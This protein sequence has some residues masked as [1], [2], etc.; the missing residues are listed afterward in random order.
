M[1]KPTPLEPE[2]ILWLTVSSTDFN[3]TPSAYLDKLKEGYTVEVTRYNEESSILRPPEMTTKKM[4]SFAVSSGIGTVKDDAE[5]LCVITATPY[6]IYIT[7]GTCF[8]RKD[9]R[10]AGMSAEQ[11]IDFRKAFQRAIE[12]YIEFR[13]DMDH[14][15]GENWIETARELRRPLD[16]ARTY[17]ELGEPGKPGYIPYERCDPMRTCKHCERP[18]TN[19]ADTFPDG[20]VPLGT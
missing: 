13:M 2:R 7:P 11:I 18:V 4:R 16:Y 8:I 20:S 17:K 15:T 10:L 9:I 19:T 6:E 5:P 1:D 12:A 14:T 3:R